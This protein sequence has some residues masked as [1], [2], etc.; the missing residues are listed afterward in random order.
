MALG[1]VVPRRRAI[2]IA[3]LERSDRGRKY[4]TL[5]PP[6]KPVNTWL[7]KPIIIMSLYTISCR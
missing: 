6:D 7:S 3:R 2:G 5:F 1:R 4:V